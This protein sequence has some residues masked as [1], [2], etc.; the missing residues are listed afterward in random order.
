MRRRYSAVICAFGLAM[1]AFTGKGFDVGKLAQMLTWLIMIVW[2]LIT[3]LNN[4][5]TSIKVHRTN[6]YKKLRAFLEEFFESEYC[7]NSVDWTRPK[8]KGEQDEDKEI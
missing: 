4:G 2:N 6:Y 3:A 8:L 5:K 7:D 1:I